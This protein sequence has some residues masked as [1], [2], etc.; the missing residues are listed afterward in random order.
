[1]NLDE[2]F[3]SVDLDFFVTL[4]S[5]ATTVGNLGQS[6][7]SAANA[8]QDYFV[9][10]HERATQTRYVSV[11]LPIVD[12][13]QALSVIEGGTRSFLLDVSM[14][15]DV[16][17]L[18]QL[19]DYGMNPSTEMDKPFIHSLMGFDRQSLSM[20]SRVDLFSA[21]FQ[22]IPQMQSSASKEPGASDAKRD[23]EALLSKAKSFDEAVNVIT[24]TT[25][26]KFI[27]FLNLEADD[28]RPEQAMSSY[29]LDSLVSIE[30]KNWMVRSFK[31][32]LQVS[33]VTSARTITHLAE[34]LA[35]RSKILPANLSKHVEGEE[36]EQQEAATAQHFQDAVAVAAASRAN[37]TDFES[38]PC[39]PLPAKEA[40]QPV[41]DL[42]AAMQN[43]IANIA[44]FALG[45]DEVETLRESVQEFLAPDSTGQKI[46][47]AIQ[48]E[49]RDP[50]V[51]NWVSKYLAEGYY[52]PMRQAVHH[53]SFMV[54]N[55]PSPVLHTQAE[56][57]ALLAVTA[58]KFRSQIDNGKVEPLFIMETPVC[59]AQLQWMFN[60]YRHPQVGM[61]EVR[62]LPGDY[63][64]VL[65]RGRLF[66]VELQNGNELV[67]FDTIRAAMTAILEH[68]QDE[69]T[70]AGILTSDSRDSW[71]KVSFQDLLIKWPRAPVLSSSHADVSLTRLC[72]FGTSFSPSVRP[73]HTTCRRLRRPRLPSI[74][75][76][77]ARR[78]LQSK[79]C[80]ANWATVSIAGTTSLFN[81]SSRPMAAP[82]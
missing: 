50:A 20:D 18:L 33:E 57:A 34:L 19:M 55:H 2:A 77:T 23:I 61:D 11:N 52:M 13:T 35:S 80:S 32:T 28:V 51:S 75:T 6:N 36:Q 24:E 82:A 14:L 37:D 8:F 7:Y 43:H 21:M 54:M 62:K 1:L 16:R 4:S 9:T 10:H 56:R 38:L 68:V 5:I 3:G 65:R 30:L 79:R 46:Y 26:E 44:H 71:A 12:D 15:F 17:E 41:P 45:D 29:G 70:W 66:R 78:R 72:R 25:V 58:T 39:C 22:T 53:A 67:S 27:R 81:S 60:T 69:G 74:L 63:C 73:T 47:Q 64:V 49:S 42:E 40:R 59:Q 48:K 31:V 76:T